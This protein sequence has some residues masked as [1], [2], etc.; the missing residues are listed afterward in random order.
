MQFPRTWEVLGKERSFK[1][2]VKRFS[3]FV[4]ENTKIELKLKYN[5]VKYNRVCNF[6]SFC[7]L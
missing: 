5:L 3:I 1:M 6:C 7:C 4:G 2:A